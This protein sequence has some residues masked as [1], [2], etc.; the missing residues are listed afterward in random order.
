MSIEIQRIDLEQLLYFVRIWTDVLERD[1]VMRQF[2][3]SEIEDLDTFKQINHLVD[4]GYCFI[5]INPKL[6]PLEFFGL[7][8]EIPFNQLTLPGLNQISHCQLKELFE[9]VDQVTDQEIIALMVLGDYLGAWVYI[10]PLV[11]MKRCSHM[12]RM[13]LSNLGGILIP[14]E[15]NFDSASRNQNSPHNPHNPRGE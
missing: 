14:P 9:S 6:S 13:L 7:I 11:E 5:R 4:T 15:G 10:N 1:E 3:S 2:E 12:C 8:N